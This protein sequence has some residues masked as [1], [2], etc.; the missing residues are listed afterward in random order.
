MGSGANALYVKALE[1]L[2]C[3]ISTDRIGAWKSIAP[4]VPEL[5]TE[6]RSHLKILAQLGKK[7]KKLFQKHKKPLAGLC[8]ICHWPVPH[9]GKEALSRHGWYL[10]MR[11]VRKNRW[12]K[13]P[14]T[15]DRRAQTSL[16]RSTVLAAQQDRRIAALRL[17]NPTRTEHLLRTQG[18]PAADS[19]WLTL[20]QRQQRRLLQAVPRPAKR[21]FK[22]EYL[23]RAGLRA[24]RP[25]KLIPN[26]P[27]G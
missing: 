14:D 12:N 21:R 7:P 6:V 27:K 16:A 24:E 11:K 3:K 5:G 10:H 19:L 20:P 17:W 1:V 2:R 22:G 15:K 4:S 26:Q 8:T 23:V 25:A 13:Y 9:R 18:R